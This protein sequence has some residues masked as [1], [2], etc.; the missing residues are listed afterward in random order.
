M[1]DCRVVGLA[2][3]AAVDA[4]IACGGCTEAGEQARSASQQLVEAVLA[5]AKAGRSDR[6]AYA[7]LG[8]ALRHDTSAG[9][10]DLV[11]TITRRL[12]GTGR[13][14][15]WRSAVFAAAEHEP[16]LADTL[17]DGW[18]A[19]AAELLEI[20][21]VSHPRPDQNPEQVDLID[22]AALLPPASAARP[23]P[24]ELAGFMPAW[25]SRAV[26]N[27]HAIDCYCSW[28]PAHSVPAAEAIDVL[29]QLIPNPAAPPSELRHLGD[30]FDYLTAAALTDEQQRRVHVQVDALKSAGYS[31]LQRFQ[32]EQT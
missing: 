31:S 12:A 30:L 18:P 10:L 14:A 4:A 24:A 8:A 21:P 2:A 15:L 3:A 13:L 22:L 1:L 20:V 32:T 17:G 23:L 19:L 16:D 27:Q 26:N 5:M 6:H 25:L 9:S 29:D 11:A 28:A 7:L